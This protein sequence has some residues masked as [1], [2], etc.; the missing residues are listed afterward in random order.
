M[1]VEQND[2]HG[3]RETRED[4]LSFRRLDLFHGQRLC[5]FDIGNNHDLKRYI[6]FEALTVF[7]NQRDK[8]RVSRL[9]RH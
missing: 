3:G 9:P 7:V 4:S 1:L 5:V 8:P 6:V 2:F